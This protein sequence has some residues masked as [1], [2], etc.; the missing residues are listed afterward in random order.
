MVALTI[1]AVN[2]FLFNL[3]F[4][5]IAVL[6]LDFLIHFPNTQ[7]FF[8]CSVSWIGMV[9]LQNLWQ[10]CCR[11]FKFF[12]SLFSCLFWL[13][14]ILIIHDIYMMIFESLKFFFM[15]VF[16]RVVIKIYHLCGTWGKSMVSLFVCL[17]NCNLIHTL[18]FLEII[19]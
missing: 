5:K 1:F 6:L 8:S 17:W 13:K 14:L 11:R 4:F 3:F 15:A 18:S 2:F 7:F 12:F 9:I 10:T 16:V 19:F